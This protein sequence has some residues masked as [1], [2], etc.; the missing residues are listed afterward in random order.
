MDNEMRKFIMKELGDILGPFSCGI[1]PNGK[2]EIKVH[3]WDEPIIIENEKTNP[4]NAPCW[5]C[6]TTKNR[7][8]AF[9][10][11]LDDVQHVIFN[12]PATIVT[13]SDGT[14]VCVKACEKDTFNKEVGLMYA[15]IKRLYA[16]DVDENGY[17]KSKGLGEKIGKVLDKAVDQKKLE[18]ERRRIRKE[19]KAKKEAEE[20]AKKAQEAN[21]AGEKA[22]QEAVN[23]V[24]DDKNA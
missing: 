11:I 13:F 20:A 5:E 19:K 24:Y 14:K 2:F 10:D 21:E 3:E 7:R 15:L 16:N 22:A 23:K 12:D 6:T 4:C 8:P 18:A 9:K 1:D 17:L